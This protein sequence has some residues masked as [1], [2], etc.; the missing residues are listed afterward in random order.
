MGYA[1]SQLKLDKFIQDSTNVLGKPFHEKFVEWRQ[2]M[3][4]TQTDLVRMSG[5]HSQ[6]LSSFER[7]ARPASDGMLDKLGSVAE[8]G[9]TPGQLKAWRAMD[10]IKSKTELKFLIQSLRDEREA[11]VKYL[12]SAE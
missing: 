3:G 12:Q 6:N 5:V 8:L 4:L 10:K 11:L 1:F 9:V 2:S 7:G